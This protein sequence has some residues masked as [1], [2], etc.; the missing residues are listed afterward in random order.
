MTLIFYMMFGSRFQKLA[1]ILLEDNVVGKNTQYFNKPPKIR[2]PPP[3]QDGYYFMLSP[4]E[5]VT[6]WMALEPVNQENSCVK[7]VK[8][9]HKYGLRSHGR[10]GTLGFSQGITDYD[11]P[12]DLENEVSPQ[13]KLVIY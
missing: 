13:Q 2:K 7:Y 11:C 6:M 9:S 1:A 5:A 12:Y 4:N 3:H 8:G 10:T